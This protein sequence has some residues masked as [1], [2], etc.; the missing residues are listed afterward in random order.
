MVSMTTVVDEAAFRKVEKKLGPELYMKAVSRALTDVTHIGEGVA[1]SVVPVVTGNLR[2][3][4]RSNL[5]AVKDERAPEGRVES[6]S[7]YAGWIEDGFWESRPGVMEDPAGGYGMF[8]AA[9][10]A[11]NENLPRY[12]DMA[13]REIETR[14]AE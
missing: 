10:E 1:K 8:R 5:S 12:L 7:R 4:I 14:F 2:R 13:A 6:D 9:Q 11:A 3:S